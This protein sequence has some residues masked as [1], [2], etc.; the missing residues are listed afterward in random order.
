MKPLTDRHL[1]G[2]SR[3]NAVSRA[4]QS[5]IHDY[6]ECGALSNGESAVPEPGNSAADQQNVS[7][8]GVRPV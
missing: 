3:L 7:A 5:G 1:C 4:Q 8:M 6:A 2:R